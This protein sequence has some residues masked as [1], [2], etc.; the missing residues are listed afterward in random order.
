M[1]P[2][3]PCRIGKRPPAP[4]GGTRP[5]IEERAV[6]G[7]ARVVRRVERGG[8]G[9]GRR[10]CVSARWGVVARGAHKGGGEDSGRE[11]GEV[12]ARVSARWGG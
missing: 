8:G 6:E 12:G 1:T 2:P 5:A 10:A 11:V 4:G 3:A 7:T 9:R